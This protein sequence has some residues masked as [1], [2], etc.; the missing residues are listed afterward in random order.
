METR[1]STWQVWHVHAEALRQIRPLALAPDQVE[2]VANRV[3]AEV[4][5]H[6][7]TSLARPDDGV[8][9]PGV[10]RRRDGTSVY[11]VAG[12]DLYTSSAV[13]AAERRL[14]EL[15]GRTD[16]RTIPDTSVDVALLE[17][18]ANGVDLDP[19]QAALVR[20]MATS[21]RRL[22]LAIAPAGTGKTTAMHALTHAWTST[23]GQVVGLAP[24]AAA[25]A[26]LRDQTAAP[27]D[28][29]AK[30][31]WSITHNDLPDWAQN[32]G[33]NSL[34]IIDEAGMA[35]TITLDTAIHWIV[36]RGGS[37]RL[38][39]DDQ[40]LAAIGAGG[41]LRDIATTHG[42]VRLTELH[43]FT[44][45]AEAAA[46]LSLREGRPEALGFYLDQRRIHV[47]DPTTSA[48]QLYAAW[49]ADRNAGLDALMLA[50]TRELAAQLNQRARAEHVGR[51]SAEAAVDLADGNQA[52]PGDVIIT[53]RNDRRLRTSPT[54]WVKNGDRWTVQRVHRDGGL[55]V[56][57]LRHGR[58]VRLPADYVTGQVELGYATTVHAAQGVTAD[59]M[60]GYVTGD[61]ARQQLYTMATRGRTANHLYLNVVGDGDPHSVIRP[62]H[63]RPNT[64]VDILEPILARDDAAR[65]ATTEHRQLHDPAVRLGDA[66]TRYHDALHTAA[67]TVAPPELVDAHRRGRGTDQRRTH[68]RAGLAHAA[69]PPAAA[70]RR[71]P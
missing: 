28:T 14:V 64:A 40:Q 10:L 2:Q 6:G 71:R 61:E 16:G 57:H 65:S 22:Q 13:L 26:Q 46:T 27:T 70:A 9:E 63:V 37:V 12:S 24:S 42:A 20:A 35:D 60:H 7:S 36:G 23:G 47:G 54:D 18:T 59:T 53:R 69:R 32:I 55:T 4:L 33:P 8:V 30:L 31:L 3:T 51:R 68:R 50:P 41:A 58:L 66:A 49:K 44:N 21:G 1:R 19:G 43:R 48:D 11:T 25:A 29:L 67:Q 45:P 15:A 17:M 62:E 56:Q 5:G 39:G 34:V 38:V 52:S